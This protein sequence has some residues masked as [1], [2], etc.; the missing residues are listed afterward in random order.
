M[1]GTRL[2]NRDAYWNALYDL[3]E[4]AGSVV[5]RKQRELR[6]RRSADAGDFS[7]ADASTIGVDLELDGLAG[8]NRRELRFL[9][10]GRHP[11]SGVCHDAH[12]RLSGRDELT[13]FDLL[14]RN[15]AGSGRRDPS[16]VEL[17]LRVL[18]RCSSRQR[19]SIGYTHTCFCRV[20][21]ST[22][23]RGLTL[24]GKKIC[25]RDGGSC[26]RGV[27]LLVRDDLLGRQLT[28]ARQILRSLVRVGAGGADLRVERGTLSSRA[29]NLRLGLSG[30]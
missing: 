21:R 4:V 7:L 5:R 26:L 27:E 29:L 3:G 23:C 2:G 25:L 18:G 9:E 13:D 24:R 28:C 19:T 20:H 15:L 8:T 12:E 14:S 16:V 11:H 30:K 1:S 6:S 17:K 22:R 10:V